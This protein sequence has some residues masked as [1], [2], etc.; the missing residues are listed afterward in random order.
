MGGWLNVCERERQ[1]T[2]EE[3][4]S[5]D[6]CKRLRRKHDTIDLELNGGII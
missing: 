5:R 6:M 3:D 2:C 1:E 4:M